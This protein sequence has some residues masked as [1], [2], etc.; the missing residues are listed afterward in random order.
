LA[1]SVGFH[2][3]T[4]DWRA[5]EKTRALSILTQVL[6]R[7]LAYDAPIMPQKEAHDLARGFLD[8]LPDARA[9]FTNGTWGAQPEVLDDKVTRGA[10]W[11]PI[12]KATFD[13][14]VI[15][16]AERESALL[17]VEDED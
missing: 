13:A 2:P 7:D 3:P 10:S 1:V 11:D 16:V 4:H 15:C 12:S 14:G 5:V 8:L 9:F 17:W 6:H